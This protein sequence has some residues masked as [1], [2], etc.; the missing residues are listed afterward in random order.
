MMT[1]SDEM[2]TEKSQKVANIFE[3]KTCDYITI[4]KNDLNK[5]F[6]TA[7]HKMMTDSDR[8]VAKVAKLA[9]FNCECGKSYKY[10]QGLSFHRKSCKEI[11]QELCNFSDNS[12]YKN[13]LLE[14][15]GQNKLLQNVII[16]QNK[17]ISE[18][19][20][21]IS[22]QSKQIS[23][24]SKQISEIIPKIGNNNNNNNNNNKIK[25]NFNV[26]LFLNEQCKDA[27]SMDDFLKNIEITV[28]D[29]LLSKDKGLAK[30]IS[31]IFINNLN[32]LP[33]IQRPLWC[34]DKKR[35]KLYIKEDKWTEDVDNNKTKG[36][37]NTISRIQSKNI[38][39]FINDKPNWMSNDKDKMT[40]LQIVKEVTNPVDDKT[41]KIIDNL[42]D[43]I[44]LTE[45]K[46]V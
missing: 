8:K 5:H 24:Q 40:Y 17:Q 2:M 29:L 43:T 15:I 18:Q 45:N 39:Q 27:I 3:C 11:S 46:I 7:K 21:Q 33:I 30:G 14:I 19:N 26:N 44:H 41:T 42:L 1:D 38:N 36:A 25:Q 4:R 23:E 32:K 20:K 10:K 35:K 31:N 12:D 37:I 28:N 34:T 9:I 6:L 22:E 13:M 16:E